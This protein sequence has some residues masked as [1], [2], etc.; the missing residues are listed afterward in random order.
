[1]LLAPLCFIGSLAFALTLSQRQGDSSSP[2][3]SSGYFR[4][5]P[6]TGEAQKAMLDKVEKI[7]QIPVESFAA[8]EF[9]A[10]NMVS[11]PYRLLKPKDYKPGV[12][13]PLVVVF[14]GS[15]AIGKDNMQHLGIFA[16]SWAQSR[17]REKYPCF[18]LA[19]QFPS[20]PVEYIVP[21]AGAIPISKPLP[22]L[23]AAIELVSA[24]SNE[25]NVDKR[26]I[27][28]MG[29]SMGGSTAINTI[30]L[31]P[32][33]FAA[34]VSIAGVPN[35]E[36]AVRIRHKPL[37]LLHGNNDEENAFAG[38]LLMYQALLRAGAKR[39]RFWEFEDVGHEAPARLFGTNELPEWIFRQRNDS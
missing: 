28:V 15:A 31:R 8:R 19:P 16:K 18:V 17:Y 11:L 25:F 9:K 21:A 35:P 36:M 26:R 4:I 10:S 39:V 1:M 29:F 23:E 24:I 27:Y 2:Q 6:L 20:R 14:H 13:Y 5:K 38:D 3:S 7:K 37:W 32:D 30:S 22:P 33:M 12:K 34:A